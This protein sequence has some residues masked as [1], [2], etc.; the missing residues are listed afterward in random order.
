MKRRTRLRCVRIVIIGVVFGVVIKYGL[1]R[2]TLNAGE[3]NYGDYFGKGGG[4]VEENATEYEANQIIKE[5][6]NAKQVTSIKSV[7]HKTLILVNKENPIQAN[8][9][10]SMRLLNS[11]RHY[12]AEILYEDL[13]DM[14]ADG[15][16]QGLSFYIV[17]GYR[18]AEKQQ[19]LIERSN[20]NYMNQGM[21][22][23]EAYLETLK[24]TLPAGYSEHETG[25]ALDITSATNTTLDLSQL[26]T[27]E[28]QWLRENC[29]K[30]GFILRYPE[31]KE[32]ITKISY[33]PWHFRYVG[34]EAA[35]YITERGL[36]LEEFL[37]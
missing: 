6:I 30:Y 15:S 1:V 34:K 26:D 27:L 4:N 20:R 5:E 16:E 7:N 11:K 2:V 19:Q 12:V 22:E 25:L 17:S 18:S 9:Q 32:D 29:H 3:N 36:T 37:E 33:E 21:T 28:N 8:Y 10:L 24:E 23:E 35:K 13:V 14:L 31:G